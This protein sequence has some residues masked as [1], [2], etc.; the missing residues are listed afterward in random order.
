MTYLI[1]EWV[2]SNSAQH[3]AN[4][5][6]ETGGSSLSIYG[7]ESQIT[8]MEYIY[9]FDALWMLASLELNQN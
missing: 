3:A 4:V 8:I 6:A 2:L 1:V 9:V 7:P 5:S